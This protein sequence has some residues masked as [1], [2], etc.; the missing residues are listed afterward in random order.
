[1]RIRFVDQARDASGNDTGAV[2][3]IPAGDER[4]AWAQDMCRKLL[5]DLYSTAT[6]P[7]GARGAWVLPGVPAGGA[8][9]VR[10]GGTI[11]VAGPVPAG[12]VAFEVTTPLT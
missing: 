12:T 6:V 5:D 9:R 1:M 3:A 11:R 4:R 7:G 8:L 2:T 10:I